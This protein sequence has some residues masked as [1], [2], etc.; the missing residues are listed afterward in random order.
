MRLNGYLMG[1]TTTWNAQMSRMAASGE[2][3]NYN[4]APIRR[5]FGLGSGAVLVYPAG[6]RIQLSPTDSSLLSSPSGS[7]VIEPD[8]WVGKPPL[9]QS[10]DAAARGGFIATFPTLQ[11][12]L[13]GG[14]VS[15]GGSGNWNLGTAPTTPGI[16][17]SND[18]Q[19]YSYG[20]GYQGSGGC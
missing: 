8:L 12:W 3:G 11:Q 13:S 20:F 15:G 6:T 2:L 17:Y 18:F 4:V 7:F 1:S 19:G 16:A 14:T 5:N 9:G 10:F